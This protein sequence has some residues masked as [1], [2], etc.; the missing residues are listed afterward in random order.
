MYQR[1]GLLPFLLAHIRARQR[2]ARGP[3]QSATNEY[4]KQQNAAHKMIMQAYG[5]ASDD[6][7]ADIPDYGQTLAK[8]LMS[9]QKGD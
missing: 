3:E 4:Q 2:A 6:T 9:L 1:R 7:E 5:S 8:A